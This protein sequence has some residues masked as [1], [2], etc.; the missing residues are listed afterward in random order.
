MSKK[1]IDTLIELLHSLLYRTSDGTFC[2]AC[3]GD[4]DITDKEYVELLEKIWQR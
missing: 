2:T 4:S 3:H 1:D